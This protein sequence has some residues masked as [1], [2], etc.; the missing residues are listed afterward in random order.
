MSTILRGMVAQIVLLAIL[1]SGCL[2][3]LKCGIRF[4]WKSRYNVKRQPCKHPR[5]PRNSTP[6]KWG[7]S[8]LCAAER[9]LALQR[10]VEA[11][12]GAGQIGNN[13]LP[14]QIQTPET[15]FYTSCA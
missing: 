8:R 2:L 13:I 5:A 6:P 11:N 9:A 3:C 4:A 10:I 1:D 14:I 7:S 15:R 12:N